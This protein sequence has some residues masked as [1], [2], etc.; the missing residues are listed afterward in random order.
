MICKSGEN[1][2]ALVH[3]CPWTWIRKVKVCGVLPAKRSH[4]NWLALIPCPA[5]ENLSL[6]PKHLKGFKVG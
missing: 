6:L 2:S 1:L 4:R 5:C 3:A